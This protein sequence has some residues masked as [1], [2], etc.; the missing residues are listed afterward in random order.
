MGARLSEDP[1][2]SVLVL[3]AGGEEEHYW[4]SHIPGFAPH[5]QVS[6]FDWEYKTEPQKYCCDALV[7]KVGITRILE[8]VWHA[9][10]FSKVDGLEARVWEVAAV[11]TT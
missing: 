11:T 4:Y 7:N 3:E 8:Q 1:S 9:S 6:D 2:V 10:S 5:L